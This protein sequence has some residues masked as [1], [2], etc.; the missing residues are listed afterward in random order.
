M[1]NADLGFPL[2]LHILQDASENS[3]PWCS[4]L[5]IEPG[6]D[7]TARGI[8]RRD[9]AFRVVGKLVEWSQKEHGT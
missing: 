2:E 3:R 1:A 4:G 7:W 8:D 9:S 6:W 5:K